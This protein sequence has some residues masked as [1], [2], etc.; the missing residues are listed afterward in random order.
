MNKLQ[1]YI[2]LLELTHSAAG[3]L[4]ISDMTNADKEMLVHIWKTT[5]NGQDVYNASYDDLFEFH[6]MSRAQ[7][8]KSL[9]KLVE[10][11]FIN[12]VGSPRSASYIVNC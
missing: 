11:G 5:Q 10:T 4:G 7:F 1:F 8:Y 2:S 12:K 3:E 6:P 9:R